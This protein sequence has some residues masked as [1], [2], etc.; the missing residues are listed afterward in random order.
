[1]AAPFSNLLDHTQGQRQKWS[2]HFPLT[3]IYGL[4]VLI[5]LQ[6]FKAAVFYM[7]IKKLNFPCISA[8]GY[9][10]SRGS[11]W[12]SIEKIGRGS[13]SSL[14]HLKSSRH[15]TVWEKPSLVGCCKVGDQFLPVKPGF[16]PEVEIGT[17]RLFSLGPPGDSL[18]SLVTSMLVVVES[19][20]CVWS[21]VQTVLN[22]QKRQKMDL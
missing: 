4:L 8:E 18:V 22:I 3:M 2:Q 20:C 21:L 10:E 7:F 6:P 15:V 16:Y 9:F 17:R 13:S 11:V 12:S 19:E 1:M 5:S 14:T